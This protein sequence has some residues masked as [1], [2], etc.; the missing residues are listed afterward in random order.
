MN[1]K[2]VKKIKS[3][4]EVIKKQGAAEPDR[5]SFEFTFEEFIP[6]KS[7]PIPGLGV[8]NLATDAEKISLTHLFEEIERDSQKV[9][10]F[11]FP[12]KQPAK[13]ALGG[14][15]SQYELLEANKPTFYIHIKDFEQ[16]NVYLEKIKGKLKEGKEIP[17]GKV[18]LKQIANIRLIESSF[19]LIANGGEYPLCFRSKRHKEDKET[20]TFKV[21]FHLWEF[22]RE[23]KN[24]KT[25][26]PGYP[27]SLSNLA[28]G[29]KCSKGAAYS[30]IKRLRERF[31]ENGFPIEIVATGTE[32]YQLVITLT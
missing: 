1:K 26:R 9:I 11:N 20:K 17:T 30:H 14:L 5:D 28:S 4:L 8:T 7:Q 22:R 29:A 27:V 18:K 2:R 13:L 15:V 24:A 3:I 6:E 10:S 12:E 25:K 23:T 21:L 19:S 16:V 31:E 32:L